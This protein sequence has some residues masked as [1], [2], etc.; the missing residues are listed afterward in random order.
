[1]SFG[2]SV[3]DSLSIGQLCWTVYRAIN[4]A[5]QDVTF[6]YELLIL[7]TR[8]FNVLLYIISE[9]TKKALTTK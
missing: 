6:M 2:Y 4:F 9:P 8:K 1:M 3:S 5:N 7:S